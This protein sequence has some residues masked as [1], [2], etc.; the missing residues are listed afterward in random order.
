MAGQRRALPPG[1]GDAITDLR[2]SAIKTQ[3]VTTTDNQLL[4]IKNLLTTNPSNSVG[5][6][7]LGR[8]PLAGRS[9]MPL[10]GSRGGQ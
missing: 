9:G 10:R 4:M 7:D 3:K 1:K 2:K 6:S 5:I 8:R